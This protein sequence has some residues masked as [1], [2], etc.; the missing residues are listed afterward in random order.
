MQNESSQAKNSISLK[1]GVMLNAVER[2]KFPP[3]STT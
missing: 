1:F 3:T 2:T